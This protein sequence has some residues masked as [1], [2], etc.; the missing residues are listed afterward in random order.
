MLWIFF[1]PKFSLDFIKMKPCESHQCQVDRRHEERLQ[2]QIL[3]AAGKE[4]AV[5]T[6]GKETKRSAGSE[7]QREESATEKLPDCRS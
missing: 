4:Q 5:V 2:I 3:K 7:A 1:Q 6:G